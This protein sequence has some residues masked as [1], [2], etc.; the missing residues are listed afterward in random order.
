M[1]PE[2]LNPQT[3][4]QPVQPSATDSLHGPFLQ[5]TVPQWLIGASAQRKAEF[6]QARPVMP[7]W[8][9]T[10]TARQ[11]HVLHASF[12]KSFRAQM[13]LDKT[14]SVFKDIDAFA[15]PILLQALKTRFQ[16]EVDVDKTLI[17][18]RR[19]V[20]AG[21]IPVE[22]G[23]V[24]TL[25]LP[26]LQA[27]LHNFESDECAFGAFHRSSGFAIETA[28][29]GTYKPVP[30]NV[31]VRKFLSLC[32]D[33]DIG[34]KYQAYLKT[35]FHPADP[36][37]QATLRRDFIAS[38]KAAIRAAA[39][40]AL[41][42][43]DI[44]PQ[45]HA[46]ILSV[47]KGETNP[48]VDNKPVWFQDMGLMRHRLVGCVAFT[49]AEKYRP[50][51]AVILYVPNDPE[52]PLKRYT[53]T[54]MRDT[55][56]R[57]LSARPAHQ[58]DTAEP[59]AYQR[60]FSQF[61]PYEQRPYYFSQFV[62]PANPWSDGLSSAWRAVLQT[63]LIFADIWKILSKPPE[64]VPEPDP[65]VAVS[66]MPHRQM[67][68]WQPNTDLWQ[69]LYETHRDKVIADARAHAV[70]TR[71]IDAKARDAKLAMLAQLGLLALNM[72]S[73]F[74]PVLG[75][76]MMVVMVGQLLYETIE[77]VIEWSEGD[78][79]AA[80]EH[81]LD[82]AENLAQ[83]ALMAG[84]GVVF[85]KINAVRPAPVIERLQP[86]TLPNGRTR[87]W[88][89]DFAGYEHDIALTR[90]AVPNQLGQY[91]IDGKTCIRQ[92]GEIYV[93]VFD[94]ATGQWRLKHPT[95]RNAHRPALAH[96]GHG[97]WRL[98]SEQPMTWQRLELLRRMGHST[99]GFSDDTLLMLADISGVSD[100]TLRQMHMDHLPP[101]PELRDAM[102][103]FDADAAARQMIEQLRG[104]RPIDE[105][106][107]HALPLVTEL[108]RW[109]YGR[110]LEI[111]A[112]PEAAQSIQYGLEKL[113]PG[114]ERKPV[115]RISRAQVL[116]GEMPARI[117]AALE[118]SEI[119]QLLGSRAAEFRPARP[120][121]LMRE[122][123]EY[124]YIRQSE[125]FDGLYRGTAPLSLRARILQRECPGLSNAAAQDVLGHATAAELARMDH[126]GRSPLRLLEEA[127][128][129][130]R[131]GRQ[132]RAFAGLH[133]ENLASADSRRL[134][135]FAL[136]Q[137][138]EW[139]PALRLE[140]REGSTTGALLDSI[141][142]PS[143]PV[144]RYLVKNGPF[145]QAFNE[146]AQVLNR[147]SRVEDSFYRSL[148]YALPD[149][150]RAALGLFEG[151]G[152]GGELQQQII[153]SARVHWREALQMLV[154]RAKWFKPPVRVRA[155]MTGYYASGR[156]GGWN[157]SLEMRVAQLY[158]LPRQAAA[159]L[160]RQRGRSDGQI[161]QELE[162]RRR[163][164]ESL[165]ATLEQWQTV[166]SSSQTAEHRARL[167]RTLREAWRNGPLAGRVAEAARL[168]LVCDTPVPALST[169]FP[170][171]RELSVS[172]MGITD[173]NVD[174]LLAA[175]PNVTDLQIGELGHPHVLTVAG[176]SLTTVPQALAQLRGLT[177]LRF[178]TDASFL[179]QTFAQRLRALT[180]LETL[181]IHYSGA[182]ASTLHSLDLS[183]LTHLRSLRIDAPHALWRWP[184][185]VERLPRLGRL[186]LTHTLIETLPESL[187]H[188]H[189]QLWAGL[190]LNWAR[191]TP[192]TFRRAYDYVSQYSGPFGHLLDVHQMV[193][194]FCRAELDTMTATG[195]LADLLPE[196]FY[197]ALATPQARV[198][199]I[200]R[201][202]TEHEAI[203]AQFYTP[204][205]RHGTRYS[206]VRSRWATGR[207][208]QVLQALKTN[209]RGTLRQRYGLTANVASF[210]LPGPRSSSEM[211]PATERFRELP[212]LPAGSFAH[213]GTVRLG[214][215]DVPID[216]ARG[217]LRAFSHVESLEISGNGFTE[218]PFAADDLRGLKNL[219]AS[220]NGIVVTPEVQRQLSGLQQ[221]RWLNLRDNPLHA[222]D[223][224]QL[225]RLRALN[226]RSASLQSW[227]VGAESLGR[228]SWLD[229]RDNRIASLPEPVLSH[230]DVLMRSNL[231]GNLF[232]PEGQASLDM[233]FQRIEQQRALE[234]GTL[235]RFAAQVV[236]DNF[237]PAETGWSFIDLLLPLPEQ[238]L[239]DAGQSGASVHVQR[240]S[241]LMPR[242][243]AEL[244]V[245]QLRASGL[246]D[247][248]IEARITEWH[249][250]CEALIRRLNGW[251]YS[252]EIPT[253]DGAINARGRSSA[254]Q[255][256][257]DA[258]L[259]GLTQARG[260]AVRELELADLRIGDLPDLPVQFPAVTTLDLT[261]VGISARGS[262][263]FLNAFDDLHT[264]FISGN[265]LGA[266]P[267]PVLR[268]RH[269]QHL[270]MQHCNLQSA[271]SLY[272]LLGRGRLRMLDVGY[273]ELRVFNP[274]DFGAVQ[275]L[276]LR[277]N[278][279]SE[280]PAGAQQA[281]HL[282]RLNLHN[283]RIVDIPGELFN[284]NHERLLQG[285][286]LSANG[287][288]SLA[289]LQDLRRYARERGAPYVLQ[290]SRGYI[291][292]LIDRHVLGPVE[293]QQPGVVEGAGNN[294]V[295][296][297]PHA[298]VLP[299][300]EI[301][302]PVNDIAPGSRDPW[303][304]GSEPEQAAQ[305]REIWTRLALESN[306]E[307]FFQLL[308]LLRDTED[309]RR[310][311]ADLTR[312]VWEVMEAATENTELRDSLFNDAETHGT[313]TDGR[314]LTFS[315]MEVRVWVYRTLRDIPLSQILARGRALVRVSRQLFR[316]EW[317]E[318][319]A[320]A[321]GQGQD[322]TEVRLQS[323]IDLTRGWGDGLDL[324]G[325]PS[326]MFYERPLT[327]EV[328]AQ[329]RTSVLEAEQ[330]DALP[331]NMVERDYWIAYLRERYPQEMEAIDVE[332][333][334]LR[335]FAGELE[336][337]LERGEIDEDQYDLQ[338]KALAK[339]IDALLRSKRLELTL[340]ELT[341]L[342]AV[343]DDSVQPGRLASQPD[344]TSSWSPSR[345]ETTT[346]VGSKLL[347]IAGE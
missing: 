270:E 45:D 238:A 79:H 312:R 240:L 91:Q 225:S 35:F 23:T 203:F 218:L 289:A 70:P 153:A 264:L 103:L 341:L 185:Y 268:M 50:I 41:L 46:M 11:R 287:R 155:K 336:D 135:L 215:L 315:D 33:L 166:P 347:P 277:T 39:E 138:P 88:K 174:G 17:S 28:T 286:D 48:R 342:Q 201:I 167:A 152:W 196:A 89:P 173:A 219:D 256:I 191:V 9:A 195:D 161:Y 8:Y 163:E 140:I 314:I 169:S 190:S 269:L 65:F 324:P 323:R 307:R 248:Q 344:A 275:L 160:A 111:S 176:R 267:D 113:L 320:E 311:P 230:P 282:R 206:T 217:F 40:R 250:S 53:G 12:R 180:S 98:V 123:T 51:E 305:R 262:N 204:T 77:G 210:E 149:D 325:Q 213:V 243:Q 162:L 235:A 226:L 184:A 260:S 346:L 59:T 292:E 265:E 52:H 36:K 55:F 168:S 216:Q 99:D 57:L 29:A 334:Q 182:D 156:G 310:V 205:L 330:T 132:T 214:L 319:F 171:V 257:T 72:A 95:E 302:D 321:L 249:R 129:H 117:L 329:V 105:R 102:Q 104:A 69:Y 283:N 78:R 318:V 304:T 22:F 309:F 266:L 293:T 276:D 145:Y 258:W 332:A 343:T 253:S 24:E 5:R 62:K 63:S 322:R 13:R 254:G 183:S 20:R 21:I 298:V 291:D 294:A 170:H 7:A 19:P 241:Q 92:G 139:S 150:M 236:P 61:M 25:T 308:R 49:V 108:P 1:S 284:G 232:S 125:I 263:G 142:E 32:R 141:G 68:P 221:V 74:V 326:H 306:H 274:P 181:D 127:R 4:E 87:L 147:I 179:G 208:A 122:L 245:Q 159:F 109:P 328:L 37:A 278:H 279:L 116:N 30:V 64:M 209:W 338:I 301:L 16:V 299:S 242:E 211:L 154:P 94:D 199:A 313:C 207:N 73:M 220:G 118:E 126:T 34:T 47:L 172:G 26:M 280:W 288:L 259:G 255:L 82:V 42:T 71:D 107:L 297:D 128:W 114:I 335:Q 178:A 81:L 106:Y 137:L 194:E 300:E 340:R 10:A 285:T 133:S 227:P 272:P 3:A 119:I 239:V 101:P 130:A 295:A 345:A 261:R 60:F 228:L 244:N 76:I 316:L 131:Q 134:A 222:I 144:K 223:V 233:A 246:S 193:R 56:K 146:Q 327:D 247:G 237:P 66:L 120:D 186:D 15:R 290:I 27:A 273:N 224:S 18:L 38:Q 189:E 281:R 6:R 252:R 165:N 67:Y 177:R 234:Q 93:Q 151:R 231:A 100:S 97:A 187:Y 54:Q 86:I 85:N 197:A 112:G 158:P 175:F 200:E 164:W 110:I 14:M 80:K 148:M 198:T 339:A 115:I 44:R 58:A 303:L 331:A 271:T 83:I 251:L 337:R 84:G 75:E 188:G 212:Q 296:P 317:V 90:S 2:S 202:R 143:A 96:N 157:T 136:E 229:L 192:T 43:K 124:A 121:E 31:S 333:E